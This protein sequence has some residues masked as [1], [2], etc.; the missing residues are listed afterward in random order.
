MR[1]GGC[2]LSRRRA[3]VSSSQRST[4]SCGARARSGTRQKGRSDLRLASLRRER[5]L[6]REARRVA[7]T[8]VDED[9][10]LEANPLLADEVHLFVTEE[11]EEFVLK[12]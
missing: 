10:V 6:V 8:I 2:V 5:A 3:T 4:S 9:P 12:G 7:E 11:E 1:P